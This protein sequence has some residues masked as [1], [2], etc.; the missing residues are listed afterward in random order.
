[1]AG[2]PVAA[3]LAFGIKEFIIINTWDNF[4]KYLLISL[5][6]LNNGHVRPPDT[7]KNER[8]RTA[9]RE[10]FHIKRFYQIAENKGE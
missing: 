7:T 4:C 5:G 3:S 6:D 10:L 2:R 8:T 9:D 1:M